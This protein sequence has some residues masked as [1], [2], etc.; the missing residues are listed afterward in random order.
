MTYAEKKEIALMLVEYTGCAD[1]GMIEE[2]I[3]MLEAWEE[4]PASQIEMPDK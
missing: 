1:T 2:F 4:E 3:A